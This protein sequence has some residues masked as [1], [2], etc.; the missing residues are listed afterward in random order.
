M[1]SFRDPPAPCVHLA[2]DISR[3]RVETGWPRTTSRVN[4]DYPDFGCGAAA[5][6]IDQVFGAGKSIEPMVE[7]RAQTGAALPDGRAPGALNLSGA[8]D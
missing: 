5:K 1:K 8:I 6:F 3:S 2:L 7:P 4:R